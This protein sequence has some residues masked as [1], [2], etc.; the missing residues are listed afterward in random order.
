MKE[1]ATIE[2]RK[3]APR[4]EVERISFASPPVDIHQDADGYTLEIEMPGVPK[5][6]VDVSFE[7]GK[8]VLSGQRERVETPGR[9][10]YRESGDHA[11]RRVFDLDPTIDAGQIS[12]SVEHG[13]LRVRLPKAEAAKPRKI[14]IA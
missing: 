2:P 5:S 6:G 8:L 11:Y 9:T 12:A 14:E 13:V 3:S 1:S 10:V 4:N 7:D